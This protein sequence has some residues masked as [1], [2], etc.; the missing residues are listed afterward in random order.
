VSKAQGQD[1]IGRMGSENALDGRKKKRQFKE[2][3]CDSREFIS[4]L[5]L[6][7]V[8][9]GPAYCILFKLDFKEEY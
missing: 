1:I 7:A 5:I 6:F 8:M 9:I 4:W 2:Y 3:C